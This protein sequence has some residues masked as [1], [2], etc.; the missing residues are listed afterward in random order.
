M[1]LVGGRG[2]VWKYCGAEHCFSVSV[3]TLPH[4][5]NLSHRAKLL[6][7]PA[8]SPRSTSIHFLFRRVSDDLCSIQSRNVCGLQRNAAIHFAVGG[9][10][11]CKGDLKALKAI[12]AA[13]C[14]LEVVN[15]S[16]SIVLAHCL[17]GVSSGEVK[18]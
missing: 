1:N 10:G 16:A 8:P 7:L 2:N 17:G 5:T 18:A 9:K 4:V 11:V 6:F 13:K 3:T 12:V 14:D 15:V